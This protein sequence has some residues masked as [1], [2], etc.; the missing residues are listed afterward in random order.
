[1]AQSEAKSKWD[2][3]NTTVITLKLNKNRDADVLQRLEEV[4]NRQGYIKQLIRGDI[5][6]G[7]E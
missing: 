4:G 7:G 6:K 5:A 2:R 3:E 1:M